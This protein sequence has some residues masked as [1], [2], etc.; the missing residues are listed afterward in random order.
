VTG[1]EP[2]PG[3]CSGRPPRSGWFATIAGLERS[4]EERGWLQRNRW[5]QVLHYRVASE[6]CAL[7][8]DGEAANGLVVSTGAAQPGQ[9]RATAADRA[10]AA[11]YLDDAHNVSGWQA[12]GQYRTP[13][14]DSNDR[15][16]RLP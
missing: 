1:C 8:I 5:Q 16:Y 2:K 7:T 9:T 12:S 10:Q 6:T 4:A 15:F 13:G 3:N 11:N 14:K